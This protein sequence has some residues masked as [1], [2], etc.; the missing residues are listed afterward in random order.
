MAPNY[1]LYITTT[2]TKFNQN[3][4]L[5]NKS[6]KPFITRLTQQES[7]K[8]VKLC[9]ATSMKIKIQSYEISKE[10]SDNKTFVLYSIR[11]ENYVK[12]SNNLSE[13]TNKLSS[14][15]DREYQYSFFE[16]F[17][18]SDSDCN[19]SGHHHDE[20]LEDDS[21]DHTSAVLENGDWT[22]TKR[23]SELHEF[24]QRLIELTQSKTLKAL[25]PKKLIIGNFKVENIEKRITQINE[26]FVKMIEL[27]ES[28]TS[29]EKI[30]KLISHF[31]SSKQQLLLSPNNPTKNQYKNVDWILHKPSGTNWFFSAPIGFE[32]FS[33]TFH[34][35]AAYISPIFQNVKI[36]Q[37]IAVWE[38]FIEQQ[39]GVDIVD[40]ND[41]FYLYTYRQKNSLFSDFVTVQ[42]VQDHEV[43]IEEEQKKI[44]EEEEDEDQV[45]FSISPPNFDESVA[46][47]LRRFSIRR[48]VDSI[49]VY[50]NASGIMPS[51]SL[52]I[53]RDD[54]SQPSVDTTVTDVKYSIVIY[55][56]SKIGFSDSNEKRVKL[57]LDQFKGLVLST[58]DSVRIADSFAWK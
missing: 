8:Y 50:N 17:D 26:Y 23:Y 41:N 58:C 1:P 47:I 15:F 49:D 48:S 25:F 35:K 39:K 56:R 36:E 53:M 10:S 29:D 51:S 52:T 5:L 28:K 24:H 40:S 34:E 7:K 33:N 43:V 44:E 22:I 45:S 32:K 46:N 12:R 30:Q 42:F 11:V 4:S 37:L 6:H 54:E 21:G 9:L 16:E 55:S 27:V 31:F 3:L 57:W 20:S 14:P 2:I 13:Q 18:Q 38:K 19:S